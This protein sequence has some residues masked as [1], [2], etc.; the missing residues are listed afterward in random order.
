MAAA[1]H[2]FS[3][4]IGF[5]LLATLGWSLSG[6]FVRLLPDLNGWQINCWRSLFMALA[7]LC[8]L[9]VVYGVDALGVFTRMPL[10]AMLWTALFFCVGT[11][12]YVTSL[13]LVGTAT[14]S[15]IGA[16]SP[17]FTGLLSPWLTRER[18][19]W[20]AWAAALAAVA[21]MAIM[22]RDGFAFGH[23][24]GLV[25]SLG[26]PLTFAGQ[27]LMLRRYREFDLMPAICLGGFMT[28]AIA[29]SAAYV[30][31]PAHAATALDLKSLGMLAVMGPLQ[32]AI[33][34]VLYS[35]GAKYVPAVTLALVSM[36]DAVINPFWTWAF[37]HEIPSRT[38]M[39]GG[40]IILSA[41]VFNILGSV[42]LRQ[43]R[44]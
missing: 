33:P 37:L 32:L 14:V 21:G 12:L 30:F 35:F 17:L 11:T 6:L 40:G 7:L 9:I 15:V 28:F 3:T 23:P 26:V 4:G 31:N 13:T 29:G 44:A 24:L 34:I 1:D 10:P 42:Y 43:H 2:R 20:I 39:I 19:H 38:D 8:Y 25:L 5:V 18:P 16:T 36:L 41:I 22:A 27:T